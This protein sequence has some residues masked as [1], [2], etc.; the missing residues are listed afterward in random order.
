M[1]SVKIQDVFKPY[2]AGRKNF[3]APGHKILP[4]E[5]EDSLAEK[6]PA[7]RPSTGTNPEIEPNLEIKTDTDSTMEH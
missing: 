1:D 3:A 4:A 2:H 6:P 7:R 5:A